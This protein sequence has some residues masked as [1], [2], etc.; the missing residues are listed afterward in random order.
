MNR[1]R[2]KFKSVDCGSKKAPFNPFGDSKSFS[3]TKNSSL[4][5][6]CGKLQKTNELIQIETRYIEMGKQTDGRT[7]PRTEK[8]TDRPSGKA[9]SLTMKNLWLSHVIRLT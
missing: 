1:F 7:D 8:R 9:E 3:Q 5:C 4:F 2:E 6:V